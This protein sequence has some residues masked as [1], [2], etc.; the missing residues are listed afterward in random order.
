VRKKKKQRRKY[1]SETD[2]EEGRKT[3]IMTKF[4]DRGMLQK[5]FRTTLDKVKTINSFAAIIGL[6][7]LVV[8]GVGRYSTLNDMF[9]FPA[10]LGCFIDASCV[11][12]FMALRK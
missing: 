4:S 8:G 11:I 1:S 6:V 7:M 10:I 2:L 9:Y 12:G 5:R 3:C